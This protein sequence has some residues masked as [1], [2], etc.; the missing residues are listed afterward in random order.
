[1]YPFFYNTQKNDDEQQCALNHV[2][3]NRKK[4]CKS[5]QNLTQIE[6]PK[7]KTEGKKHGV[8]DEGKEKTYS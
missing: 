4:S 8:N 7:I 1:M 6:C 3:S 2:K 5:R